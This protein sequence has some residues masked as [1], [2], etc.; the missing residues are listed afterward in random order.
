VE[1]VTL[2]DKQPY[3]S[4]RYGWRWWG[5]GNYDPPG[6]ENLPRQIFDKLI[7]DQNRIYYAKHYPTEQ[8]AVADL[9]RVL[10]NWARSLVDPPLPPLE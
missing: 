10:V 2:T 1:R 4:V 5:N 9:S 8:A 3:K 6:R 7:G